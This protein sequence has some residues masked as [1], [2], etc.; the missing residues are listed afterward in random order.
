M[1]APKTRLFF[2]SS[3]S[4]PHS[5]CMTLFFNWLNVSVSESVV[6]LLQNCTIFGVSSLHN[7]SR[8]DKI[9]FYS[10]N[11]MDYGI[12]VYSLPKTPADFVLRGTVY[13]SSS[14]GRFYT[15]YTIH[16]SSL[17]ITNFAVCMNFVML[18]DFF[19]FV[20]LRF[21]LLCFDFSPLSLLN[22][23]NFLTGEKANT[24]IRTRNPSRFF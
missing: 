23:H 4:N 12:F 3:S 9:R 1:K 18:D 13:T 22:K 16:F 10:T 6:L 24:I 14:N 21:V 8:F 11:A 2:I 20:F 19:L 17:L 7:N 15:L 5:T